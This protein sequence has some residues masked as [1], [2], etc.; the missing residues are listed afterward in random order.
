MSQAHNTA[1]SLPTL[2]KRQPPRPSATAPIVD[3]SWKP[4][5]VLIVAVI[6]LAL[7]SSLGGVFGGPAL[8]DHEA[9]VAQCA[10]EMRLSG[11]WLVPRFPETPF[12]RKSPLPFW[13]G[14]ACSYLFGNDPTTGLPVTAAASRLG[15]A[16]CSFGS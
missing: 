14:A 6:G 8:G 11:D 4:H 10:R 15:S 9:I 12:F 16:L 13:M 5:A 2:A 3:R 1:A 7:L